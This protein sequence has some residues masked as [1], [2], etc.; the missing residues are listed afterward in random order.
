MG[1]LRPH[2]AVPRLGPPRSPHVCETEQPVPPGMSS[3]ASCCRGSGWAHPPE[4]KGP[5][6]TCW[7]RAALIRAGRLRDPVASQSRA[8][9]AAG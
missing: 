4:S 7:G 3:W 8:G 2:I 6:G 9:S 5:E 1:S